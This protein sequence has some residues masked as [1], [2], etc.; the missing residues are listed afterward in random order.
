MGKK[1]VTITSVL[2]E[3]RVLRS[4]FGKGPLQVAQKLLLV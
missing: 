1:R 4:V 3:V 2:S